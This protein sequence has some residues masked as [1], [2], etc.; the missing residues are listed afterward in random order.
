M[1]SQVSMDN[2]ISYEEAAA[3][4]ANPPSLAPCPIFTNL[5]NL[6]HHIQRALQRLSC[7]QSNIL[8][9]AGLIMARSMYNLLT[10]SPFR[11]PILTRYQ[12]RYITH[13][14]WKLL[15][16]RAILSST[17]QETPHIMIH[18][19]SPEWRNQVSMRNSNE[20]K[21]TTNRI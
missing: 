1:R 17:W 6:R 18:L 19:T 10:S 21:I 11:L 8:G 13:P 7:P 20:Q 3:L 5:R 16:R 14:Q 4:V 9:W 15:M 2:T 12:W